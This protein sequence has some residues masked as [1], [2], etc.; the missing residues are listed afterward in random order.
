M[1]DTID[2]PEGLMIQPSPVH[3]HGVFTTRSYKEGDFI[4]DFVYLPEQVWNIRD[5][6]LKYGLSNLYTYRMMRQHKIIYVG[7][8][9]NYVSYINENR[10]DPNVKLL[11]KKLYALKDINEGDELFLRYYY[12]NPSINASPPSS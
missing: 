2:A 10:D 8:N 11:R 5:Y 9:R 1:P 7:D 4:C 3:G 6:R 12:S